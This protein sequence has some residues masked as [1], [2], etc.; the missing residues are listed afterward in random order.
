MYWLGLW[1]GWYD[2]ATGMVTQW[3]MIGVGWCFLDGCA[4]LCLAPPTPKRTERQAWLVPAQ[5]LPIQK[6]FSY[7]THTT[8]VLFRVLV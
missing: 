8:F 6:P 2:P 5:S 4:S 7:F 3:L 1:P